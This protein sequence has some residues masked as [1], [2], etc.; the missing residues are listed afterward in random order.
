MRRHHEGCRIVLLPNTKLLNYRTVP[1]NVVR[2]EVVEQPSSLANELQQTSPG[3]VILGVR[4]Q[5]IRE[6]RNSSAENSNLNFRCSR[7]GFGLSVLLHEALFYF[8]G[9]HLSSLDYTI[10]KKNTGQ[11][12]FSCKRNVTFNSYK[13]RF[14]YQ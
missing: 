13:L 8:V 7:I 3:G 1:T 12:G 14:V 4:L 6:F 10:L 5:V 11:A 2:H 9:Y